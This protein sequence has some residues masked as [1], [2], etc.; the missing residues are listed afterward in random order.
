[1]STETVEVPAAQV[2]KRPK[3]VHAY[4]QHCATRRAACGYVRKTPR[5][6]RRKAPADCVVCLDLAS[7]MYVCPDCGNRAWGGRP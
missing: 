6:P 5:T 7:P 3:I 1:M 2:T 4:C